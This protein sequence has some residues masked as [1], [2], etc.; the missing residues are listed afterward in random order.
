MRGEAAAADAEAAWHPRSPAPHDLSD[1][2]DYTAATSVSSSIHAAM[3]TDMT[4]LG[5]EETSR[6]DVVYEKELVDSLVGDARGRHLLRHA[7][8][9]V[10]NHG[11]ALFSPRPPPSKQTGSAPA[12]P[13]THPR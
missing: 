2:S 6:M 7:W 8:L 1:E 3:R 4:D 5:S 13:P 9:G 11:R 12:C 10:A